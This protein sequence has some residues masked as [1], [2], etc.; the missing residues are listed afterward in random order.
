MDGWDI[1]IIASGVLA[2]S[3]F[4]VAMIHIFKKK[5][6]TTSLGNNIDLVIGEKC[7]VTDRIDNKAGCGQA[8]VNGLVWS[9]R[10]AFDDV[11]YEEGEVL[12]ILAVEG[13]KLVCKK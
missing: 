5:R 2:L 13:V 3:A 6:N 7:I 4:I 1:V 9:A 8:R 11:C 10:S 12:Q